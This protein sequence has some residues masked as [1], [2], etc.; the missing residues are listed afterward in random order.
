MMLSPRVISAL[1]LGLALSQATA[2][3]AVPA[4]PA[5]PLIGAWHGT[6]MPKLK[7]PVSI[8]LVLLP[9]GRFGER[10]K[11]KGMKRMRFGR[12]QVVNGKIIH[13]KVSQWE[14]ERACTRAGCEPI[15]IDY[16]VKFISAT[17]LV[18]QEKGRAAIN[19]QR[20]QQVPPTNRVAR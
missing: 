2:V 19:F 4:S 11:S 13:F 16:N 10:S 18:L 15:R 6:A 14:P 1:V 3:D 5:S 17:K 20:V 7:T 12:Y 8:D 9:D